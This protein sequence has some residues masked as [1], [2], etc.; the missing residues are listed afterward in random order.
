[1]SFLPHVTALSGVGKQMEKRL[2][3]HGIRTVVSLRDS[4]ALGDP[5]PDADEERYCRKEELYYFRLAPKHWWA[6][7]G[8][9]P[10]DEN[11]RLFLK[12]LDDPK[13]YPVLIHCFAGAHRTGAYCAI[14]RM[15]HDHWSNES[16]MRELFTGGYRN[17]YDEE[18]IRTYL[19]N[20]TPRWRR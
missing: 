7:S 1:M 3:G 11:V 4:Y 6:E 8:P 16:A 10:A 13:Y 18:D 5:A 9:A 20:Y 14:Y 2:A 17:L 15:E 19:E 12:I